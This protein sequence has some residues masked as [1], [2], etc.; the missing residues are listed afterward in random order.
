VLVFNGDAVTDLGSYEYELG[1]PE[2]PLL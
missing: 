1:E 2:V